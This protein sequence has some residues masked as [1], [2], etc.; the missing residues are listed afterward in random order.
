MDDDKLLMEMMEVWTLH[1]STDPEHMERFLSR[2]YRATAMEHI[3]DSL[4]LREV[5]DSKVHLLAPKLWDCLFGMA[6]LNTLLADPRVSDIKFLAHNRIRLKC[7]GS[8]KPSKYYFQSKEQYLHFLE[9]LLLRNGLKLASTPAM[10]SFYDAAYRP[11]D[12][13]CF[14]ISSNRIT[15]ANVPCLHLHRM[16]KKKKSLSNLVFEGL[17]SKTAADCLR[18]QAHSGGSILFV[19]KDTD[20]L[21]LLMNALLDVIP[22]NRSVLAIQETEEL[23]SLSHPEMMFQHT[24]PSSRSQPACETRELI[25]Y[26]LLLDSDYFIVD[27]LNQENALSFWK[28]VRKGGR[29]WT[30]L[31]AENAEHALLKLA[32]FLANE[33]RTPKELLL[34]S[35]TRFQ[36]VVSLSQ[37]KVL[38]ISAVE[39][40]D[41]E[42]ETIRLRSILNT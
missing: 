11:E 22:H 23:F 7:M 12:I 6:L 2:D 1:I 9:Y 18:S 20:S 14:H 38:D 3:A 41:K 27:E 28:A 21:R 33:T 31:P 17:L 39:G 19:G 5:P 4:Y 16:P 29:C 13:L 25:E 37:K 36:C 40:W 32:D 24:T 42:Q 15:T 35:F 10:L 30:S 8:R 34:P 26:G